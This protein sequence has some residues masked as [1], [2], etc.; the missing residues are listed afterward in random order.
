MQ[1]VTRTRL[2][3]VVGRHPGTQAERLLRD[4]TAGAEVAVLVLGLMPT[5]AQQRLTEDALALAADRRLFLTAELVPNAATLS[6]LLGENDRVV[7]AAGRWKRR[8]LRAAGSRAVSAVD[9]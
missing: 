4:I 7:V 6:R 9:G 3:I 5:P 2:V 8:L 1:T